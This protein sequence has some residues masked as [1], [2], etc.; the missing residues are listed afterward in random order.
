MGASIVPA[1]INAQNTLQGSRFVRCMMRPQGVNP[2]F[3]ISLAKVLITSSD[4][5][6]AVLAHKLGAERLIL[7]QLKSTGHH[8]GQLLSAIISHEV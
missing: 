8:S 3:Y 2:S 6:E 7:A 4:C 1:V 5:I